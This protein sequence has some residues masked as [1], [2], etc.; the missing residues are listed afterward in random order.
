MI[1]DLWIH[2]YKVYTDRIST[3]EVN[4]FMLVEVKEN[5][6]D[7]SFSQHDTLKVADQL[8]RTGRLYKHIFSADMKLRKVRCWGVHVLCLSSNSPLNSN[9]ILWDGKLIDVATLESLLTFRRDPDTLQERSE[10]RHH[11]VER[12]QMSFLPR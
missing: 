5:N 3:R 11:T 10:R 7:L 6:A 1:F 4:N 12:L 9:V 8:I 2:Q